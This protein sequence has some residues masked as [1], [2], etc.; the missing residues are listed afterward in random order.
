MNANPVARDLIPHASHSSLPWARDWGLG[1][2]VLE[3]QSE[4]IVGRG[5]TRSVAM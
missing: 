4:R 1:M 2:K 5:L 3:D